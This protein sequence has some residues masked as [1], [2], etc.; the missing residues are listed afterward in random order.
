MNG[1]DETGSHG[2]RLGVGVSGIAL[3]P[4]VLTH[5][6]SIGIKAGV[7]G[8]Q[9]NG[10]ETEGNMLLYSANL[11]AL[12]GAVLKGTLE[13]V[14]HTALGIAHQKVRGSKDWKDAGLLCCSVAERGGESHGP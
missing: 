12:T 7:D 5:G 9:W 3:R 13:H 1:T 10:G 8:V 4:A 11:L 2:S 14:A 6:F